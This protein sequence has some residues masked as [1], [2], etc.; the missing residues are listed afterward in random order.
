MVRPK[1]QK[2]TKAKS[3]T[4]VK[5]VAV[6]KKRRNNPNHLVYKM[7]VRRILKHADKTNAVQAGTYKILDQMFGQV[8]TQI[9]SQV[10]RLK[11]CNRKRKQTK[12]PGL[13]PFDIVNA[14][15]TLIDDPEERARVRR[16]VH[17]ALLNI[18]TY[19]DQE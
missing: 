18:H 2:K 13:K 19:D 16:Q 7:S 6:K 4:V 11:N 5:S 1:V 9:L 15:M 3:N 17:D 14:T 8:Q 10:T 12:Q